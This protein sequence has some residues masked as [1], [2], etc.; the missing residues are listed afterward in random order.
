[1][2]LD[3]T[4]IAFSTGAFIS[5]VYRTPVIWHVGA[6]ISQREWRP[7]IQ[8]V[9]ARLPFC[10]CLSR[11]MPAR[12]ASTRLTPEPAR[13]NVPQKG[14][15]MMGTLHSTNKDFRIC[16]VMRRTAN[17][18]IPSSQPGI[19]GQ[20]LNFHP[21]R[22]DN[23]VYSLP[24]LRQHTKTDR[25]YGGGKTTTESLS[26]S[27][28]IPDKGLKDPNPSHETARRCFSVRFAPKM[29]WCS[30]IFQVIKVLTAVAHRIPKS[31]E[32][33]AG[34]RSNQEF[35][36]PE[37]AREWI[38]RWSSGPRFSSLL[39]APTRSRLGH[40]YPI[41]YTIHWVLPN[42]HLSVLRHWAFCP[43]PRHSTC[44]LARKFF[45]T[46]R[47]MSTLTFGHSF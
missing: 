28:A 39:Q 7:S 20:V 17:Y 24:L 34:L 27:W 9:S 8:G 16:F 13:G 23:S 1:M 38:A 41:H 25:G 40:H 42:S 6:M 46:R 32:P 44:F 22:P 47:I 36:L 18:I 5:G 15:R 31:N 29:C 3:R 2:D 4:G 33:L 14:G 26:G 11:N 45:N 12:K 43:R 10:L 35:L 19:N 21:A 37:S 30:T